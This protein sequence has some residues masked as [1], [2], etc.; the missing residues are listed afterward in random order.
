MP[1][2][3]FTLVGATTRLGLLTPPMRAR[4]GIE[5]R[6]NFFRGLPEGLILR[7]RLGVVLGVVALG[8]GLRQR[9]LE[10]DRI[11][12]DVLAVLLDIQAL[13]T[14]RNAIERIDGIGIRERGRRFIALESG[15]RNAYDRRR[16]EQGN[17]E[18]GTFHVI[19]LHS[20]GYWKCHR[21][22]PP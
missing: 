1:I 8:A 9:S 22:F 20:V 17:A 21:S 14:L 16:G 7:R 19:L 12:V 11:G 10:G 4:F 15:G 5:Q 13:R 18:M 2:E 3:K 6:L